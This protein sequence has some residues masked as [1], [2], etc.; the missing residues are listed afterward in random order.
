M[1][2][3]AQMAE[4]VLR[5]PEGREKAAISREYAALWQAAH[6]AGETPEIGTAAPPDMPAR[7][8]TPA[9]L[10]PRDVPR[11]KPGT[12]E[13]RIA[14]LHAVAHIELNVADLH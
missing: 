1:I 14:I 4:H 7:P 11:R 6:A 10:D 8:A 12:P 13:G 9:L 5:A 3:L 2:P